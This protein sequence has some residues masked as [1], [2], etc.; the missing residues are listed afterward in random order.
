MCGAFIH[1]S[2]SGHEAAQCRDA[3][4]ASIA[5]SLSLSPSSERFYVELRIQGEA[6]GDREFDDGG[7]G[8]G[9]E[10]GGRRA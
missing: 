4:P 5:P 6:F 1:S 2:D 7:V 3:T 8:Q 10:F 9:Q